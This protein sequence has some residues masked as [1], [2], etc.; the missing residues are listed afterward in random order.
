MS[1]IRLDPLRP[2][3]VGLRAREAWATDTHPPAGRHTEGAPEGR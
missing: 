2:E 3:R 1:S